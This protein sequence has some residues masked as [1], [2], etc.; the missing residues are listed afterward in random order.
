MLRQFIAILFVTLLLGATVGVNNYFQN[1]VNIV[2]D[3]KIDCGEEECTSVTIYDIFEDPYYISALEHVP[4]TRYWEGLG[5]DHGYRFSWIE[6][7]L[8][9]LVSPPPELG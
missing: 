3:T 5:D 6:D 4:P 7:L 2:L 9:N 8:Y 1:K